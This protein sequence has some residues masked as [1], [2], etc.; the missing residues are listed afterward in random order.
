MR[1]N[2]LMARRHLQADLQQARMRLDIVLQASCA[3]NCAAQ[4]GIAPE[5]R[6][7]ICCEG[8]PMHAIRAGQAKARVTRPVQCAKRRTFFGKSIAAPCRPV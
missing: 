3:A 5:H 6:F 7:Q 8:R 1:E 4:K 2:Q